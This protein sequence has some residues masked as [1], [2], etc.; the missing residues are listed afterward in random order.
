MHDAARSS[1]LA[2]LS[3]PAPL[4]AFQEAGIARLIASKNLLLADEM[5]LGKTIQV[6]AAIRLLFAQ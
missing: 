3:W 6:I 2:L 4:F 5:G 1:D